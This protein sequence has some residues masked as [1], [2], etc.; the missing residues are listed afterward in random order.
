LTV[1]P[2]SSAATAAS[3]RVGPA[4]LADGVHRLWWKRVSNFWLLV[5]HYDRDDHGCDDL[6][7]VR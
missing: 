1:S 5:Y 3:S 7:S 6:F 2:R 4:A